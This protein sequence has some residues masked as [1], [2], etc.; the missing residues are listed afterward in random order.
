[1]IERNKREEK[2][3]GGGRRNEARGKGKGTEN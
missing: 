2:K 1:M 3:M